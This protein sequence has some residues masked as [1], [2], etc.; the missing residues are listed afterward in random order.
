MVLYSCAPSQ[1]KELSRAKQTL[2]QIE[3]SIDGRDA[4]SL[5]KLFSFNTSS[6]IAQSDLEEVFLTFP[7]GITVIETEYDDSLTVTD[8]VEDDTYVKN[9]DWFRRITDNRTGE[10][11]VINVLQCTENWTD[12]SDLGIIRI[13]LY[14]L[15]EYEAFV[16]WWN[17]F[18]PEDRPTG[19]IL[20]VG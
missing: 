14:P 17:T 20:F 3:A 13:I 7:D 19:I 10:V 15:S 6:A 2:E 8:W 5:L 1:D 4:D 12:E 11:Y 16:N 18:E 9:I